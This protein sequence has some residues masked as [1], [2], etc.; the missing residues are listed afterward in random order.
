M[1]KYHIRPLLKSK[2]VA[3]IIGVSL[4]MVYKMQKDGNGPKYVI[5]NSSQNKPCR[6]YYEDDIYE[7]IEQLRLKSPVETPD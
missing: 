2:D 4:S 5:L 6:R 7:Y 3:K 1:N